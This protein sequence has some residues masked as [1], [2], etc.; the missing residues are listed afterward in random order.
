MQSPG[1]ILDGF[2]CLSAIQRGVVTMELGVRL[3][4]QR[5]PRFSCGPRFGEVETFASLAG[6]QV[7]RFLVIVV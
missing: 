5:H 2:T 6:V 1:E 4:D 3:F 7:E